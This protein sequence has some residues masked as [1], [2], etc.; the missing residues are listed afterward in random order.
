MLIE[1]MPLQSQVPLLPANPE[2]EHMEIEMDESVA[3]AAAKQRQLERAETIR[4]AC[5]AI[6]RNAT[7]SHGGAHIPLICVHGI[8]VLADCAD[9]GAVWACHR[10][11]EETNA[12]RYEELGLD[13]RH[14]RYW[15][16]GCGQ[17]GSAR[18]FVELQVRVSSAVVLLLMGLLCNV[19]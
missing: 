2:A 12:V 19:T 18:I 8:A 7:A 4:C 10:R 14:N 1:H 15:Q 5:P 17:P 11:A 13:R 3:N 9:D 16:F 6:T